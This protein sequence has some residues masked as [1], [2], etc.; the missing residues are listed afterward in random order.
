MKSVLML[1]I[2]LQVVAVGVQIDPRDMW[3]VIR[4]PTWLLRV[5]IAMFVAVPVL[6]VILAKTFDIPIVMRGAIVL[7][8]ISAAAPLLPGK[9]LRLGS[10][11]T[12]DA[13]LAAVTSVLAI[14]LVPLAL[15]SLGIAF[16][17]NVGITVAAVAGVLMTTFLLPLGV[18]MVARAVLGPARAVP[19]GDLAGDAGHIALVILVLLMIVA[20]RATVFPLLWQSVTVIALFAAG[21]L[22]IGHLLGGPD[23]RE[24]TSLAIAAVTRHP[25]LALLM[26]SAN[27]RMTQEMSLAV[28]AFVL[29]TALAT[30]PYIIWRMRVLSVTPPAAFGAPANVR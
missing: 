26:A 18:G 23:P 10:E 11:I 24:R 29:G 17:R 16:Q 27:F 15:K 22:L 28:V 12:H 13:T 5:A 2:M 30:I 7:L 19:L 6:A 4:R 3:P 21:A 20:Q 8:A 9:L 14:V 1:A 25:G